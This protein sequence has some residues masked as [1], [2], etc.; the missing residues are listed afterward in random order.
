[1]SALL[2]AFGP[3]T[4][5][6]ACRL[7]TS[8]PTLQ[9]LTGLHSTESWAQG[10]LVRVYGVP[11]LCSALRGSPPFGLGVTVEETRG[12][13]KRL[14]FLAAVDEGGT[15]WTLPQVGPA[16]QSGG[17]GLA[18]PTRLVL[19]VQVMVERARSGR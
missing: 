15:Q 16:G 1:M 13:I 2:W 8:P 18:S 10:P 3:V 14:L 6:S 19:W 12:A 11:S 9:V 17:R 7:L 5:E 4:Q